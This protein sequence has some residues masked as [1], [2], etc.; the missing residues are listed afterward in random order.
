MPPYALLAFVSAIGYSLGGL[1]NKQAMAEGAGLL[2]VNAVSIWTA[3]AVV[4]PF[5]FAYDTPIPWDVWWQPL[6][7]G[8]CFLSGQIFFILALQT[9]DI[10]L[11]TPVAGAKPIINA[12]LDSS[13]SASPPQ[14][15][16]PAWGSFV[17]AR[18]L[19]RPPR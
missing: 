6:T 1:F 13:A 19:F 15:G 3:A 10:S 9:G 8:L 2:R 16:P 4:L 11:V 14:L 18:L 7:A 5:L 12:L 17:S